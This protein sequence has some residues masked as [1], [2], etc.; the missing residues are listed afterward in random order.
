MNHSLKL[1]SD[2]LILQIEKTVNCQCFR[3]PNT[4]SQTNF[5]RGA[6]LKNSSHPGFKCY[7]KYTD[8]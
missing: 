4:I 3:D 5:S 1:I 7:T 8:M 6:F 2:S